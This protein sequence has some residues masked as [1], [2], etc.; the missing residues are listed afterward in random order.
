[1][2][3]LKNTLTSTAALALVVAPIAV[4]A[5]SSAPAAA[6]DEVCVSNVTVTSASSQ[7]W[8]T[9][10]VSADWTASSPKEGQTFTL[11]LGEGLRWP[12]GVAFSLTAQ[13]TK[14]SVGTCIAA[15]SS[16]DLVCT[17]NKNAENWDTLQGGVTAYGQIT[18]A[19]VGRTSSTLTASGITYD[20]V[21]GDSD[22]DGLSNADCGGVTPPRALDD[23]LEARV[24]QGAPRGRHQ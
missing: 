24:V 12:A 4:V 15:G 11:T 19:L 21:P 8:S 13:T 1:M 9:V 16:S 22:G 17:L 2:K 3:L 18:D 20:L 7:E 14:Q 5:S 23:G 10:A 6:A